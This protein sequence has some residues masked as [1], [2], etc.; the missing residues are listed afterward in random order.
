MFQSWEL[1]I[2]I[3]V[4]AP[5]SDSKGARLSDSEGASPSDS[6]GARWSQGEDD[7]ASDSGGHPSDRFLALIRVIH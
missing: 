4:G 5:A 1:I 6:E 7:S 3:S 2:V